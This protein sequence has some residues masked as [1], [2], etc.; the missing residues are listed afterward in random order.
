MTWTSNTNTTCNKYHKRSDSTC[1]RDQM[2]ISRVCLLPFIKGDVIQLHPTLHDASTRFPTLPAWRQVLLKL[3]YVPFDILETHASLETN[4]KHSMINRNVFF[5][6]SFKCVRFERIF[7]PKPGIH[8]S[9]LT[10]C[11]DIDFSHVKQIKLQHEQ[12]V[13]ETT[14]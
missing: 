6:Q 8:W 10:G 7:L 4:P 9:F 11:L 5:L 12:Y 13:C 1:F 3:C 2:V 14:R